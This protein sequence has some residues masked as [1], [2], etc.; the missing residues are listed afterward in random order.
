LKS[1][2]PAIISPFRKSTSPSKLVQEGLQDQ[3]QDQ[4][5][6]QLGDYVYTIATL[7]S[8]DIN[9]GFLENLLGSK[10]FALLDERAFLE[11]LFGFSHATVLLNSCPRQR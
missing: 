6:L 11:D 9:F 8:E 3:D 7:K 10:H 2:I 1:D 4:L 5:V